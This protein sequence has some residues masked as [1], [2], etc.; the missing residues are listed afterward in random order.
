MALNTFV[1]VLELYDGIPLDDALVPLYPLGVTLVRNQYLP[2]D[3]AGVLQNHPLFQAR[4]VEN[5]RWVA[6]QLDHRVAWNVLILLPEVELIQ[7]DVALLA[8][9][10][11]IY[12]EFHDF[13]L[14]FKP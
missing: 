10:L 3:G 13:L 9:F 12:V 5:V 4:G 6:A 2:A 7:A 14:Y 1:F 11:Q 8:L